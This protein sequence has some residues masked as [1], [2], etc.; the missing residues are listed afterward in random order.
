MTD[1]EL[2]KLGRA[3]LIEIIY[4]LQKRDNEARKMIEDLSLK[5]EEQSTATSEMQTLVDA[6]A[7][8]S[9]FLSTVQGASDIYLSSVRELQLDAEAEIAATRAVCER[10][11]EM[12]R[13]EAEEIIRSANE[14][15]AKI[16]SDA[17]KEAANKWEN[18]YLKVKELF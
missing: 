12:A 1:K 6:A 14:E 9:E 2:R 8:I 7:K 4:E 17:E 3:D 18:I 10:A 5:L 15:R 11:V 16:I 13:A